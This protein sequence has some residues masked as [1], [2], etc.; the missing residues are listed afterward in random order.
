M[1]KKFYWIKLKAGLKIFYR[2]QVLVCK[3][4]TIVFAFYVYNFLIFCRGANN[5][6]AGDS[7]VGY[8]DDT[9]ASI[10]F[11]IFQEVDFSDKKQ[12]EKEVNL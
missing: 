7:F 1:N 12:W 11:K 4:C 2:F 5:F 8:Q 10:V 3:L 9:P 6:S